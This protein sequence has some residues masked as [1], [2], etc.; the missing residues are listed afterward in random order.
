[1]ESRFL[2]KS[3]FMVVLTI[4]LVYAYFQFSNSCSSSPT[5]S[6]PRSSAVKKS[7]KADHNSLAIE[8]IAPLSIPNNFRNNPKN[9]NMGYYPKFAYTHSGTNH[10]PKRRT[11]NRK[12]HVRKLPLFLQIR[13]LLL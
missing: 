1:M 4:P 8:V 3:I 10:F 11:K 6:M 12:G 2:R 13:Q 9:Q 5:C 7:L